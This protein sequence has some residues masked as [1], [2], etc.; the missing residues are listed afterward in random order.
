MN[1][2]VFI[3]LDHDIPEHMWHVMRQTR[4]LWDGRIIL[5]APRRED[6]Y[7]EMK[8]L[9]IEFVQQEKI[10]DK[11]LDE[12]NAKTFLNYAGWDGFWDNACKRFFY[13]QLLMQ[14]HIEIEHVLYIENDVIPYISINTMFAKFNEVY[15]NNITFSRFCEENLSCCFMYIDNVFVI[16]EFCDCILKYYEMGLK[17]I[18]AMVKHE[19]IS[20][21]TLAYLFYKQR[22]DIVEL[23][24]IMP[25][26]GYNKNY[27]KLGFF[28]D[29]FAYGQWVGGRRVEPGKPWALDV[30]CIGCEIL[31]KNISVEMFYN[32]SECR[33]YP[34]INGEYPLAN[35][36]MH[37]KVGMKQ[38]L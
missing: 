14:A 32:A 10:T 17:Q 4:K 6:T 37:S 26:V 35:L 8:K 38:W 28:I 15:K 34:L 7:V 22:P 3:Q 1:S 31:A 29:P 13:I 18:T 27:D 21:T 12:Y 5:I 20:E 23:F 30:D 36:H 33:S 24:P 16:K 2:V 9:N 25:I 19:I 11:L